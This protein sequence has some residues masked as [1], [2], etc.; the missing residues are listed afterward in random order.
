MHWGSKGTVE[1]GSQNCKPC[2]PI[3]MWQNC[4]E[5]CRG[6]RQECAVNPW[7]PYY[8]ATHNKPSPR[9]CSKCAQTCCTCAFKRV[10]CGASWGKGFIFPFACYSLL[11]ST[12]SIT[13]IGLSFHRKFS[14]EQSA[15]LSG[16]RAFDD[17]PEEEKVLDGK[18]EA[19]CQELRILGMSLALKK[20][21]R[22]FE[23]CK[24]DV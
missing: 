20:D 19:G 8:V 14:R 12:T 2:Q 10:L 1:M 3:D 9:T 16:R 11:T 21:A 22:D 15:S 13:L 6:L 23:S 24:M 17:V 18:S 7:Q 5:S 4:L